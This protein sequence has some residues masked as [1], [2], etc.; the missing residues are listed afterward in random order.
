M[1]LLQG[2][3]RRLHNQLS[4]GATVKASGDSDDDD[5]G[6][7]DDDDDDDDD[8]PTEPSWLLKYTVAPTTDEEGNQINGEAG[9]EAHL[10]AA[11]TVV[12]ADCAVAT[13]DDDADDVTTTR[14]NG[15]EPKSE[16]GG[17]GAADSIRRTGDERVRSER[18]PRH[19]VQDSRHAELDSPPMATRIPRHR[20][21]ERRGR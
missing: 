20:H 10:G 17:N 5:D 8:K 9:G 14:P 19:S 11:S 6:D 1:E 12:D 2:E 18:E 16:N 7:D 4:G 21:S 13:A 15:A 3:N